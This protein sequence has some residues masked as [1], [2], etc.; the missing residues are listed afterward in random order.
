MCSCCYIARTRLRGLPWKLLALDGGVPL[1]DLEAYEAAMARR[2]HIQ[3]AR[4]RPLDLDVVERN[5][6]FRRVNW[7]VARRSR[8][9]RSS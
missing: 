1:K 9:R 7:A 6:R 5:L 8:I 3:I 2:F 4:L